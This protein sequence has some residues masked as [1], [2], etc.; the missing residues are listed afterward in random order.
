MNDFNLIYQNAIEWA[1][2][3]PKRHLNKK[4]LKKINVLLTVLFIVLCN[5]LIGLLVDTV[6]VYYALILLLIQCYPI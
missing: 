2:L 6:Y 3:Y 5:M 4:I 1:F